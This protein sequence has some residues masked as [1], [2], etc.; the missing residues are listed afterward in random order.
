MGLISPC[1]EYK[2]LAKTSSF[3]KRSSGKIFSGMTV[4]FSFVNTV[5]LHSWITVP[6]SF[7]N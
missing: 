7:G 2:T 1:K 4:P 3:P 5:P 6:L